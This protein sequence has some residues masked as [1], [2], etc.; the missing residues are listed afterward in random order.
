MVLK[1]KTLGIQV[2]LY[3][4][5]ARYR[6]DLLRVET[7]CFAHNGDTD[8][9]LEENVKEALFLAVIKDEDK[10]FGYCLMERRWPETAYMS[11]VAIEPDYQ[12][13]GHLARLVSG[14]EA[15]LIR[16]GFT[17]I[18]INARIENGYAAKIAKAYAGRIEFQYDHGSRIGPLTFFRIVLKEAA[19]AGDEPAA[20]A[21][22]ASGG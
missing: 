11:I 3:A 15:E 1:K 14:V 10:A 13:K 12:G 8:E 9:E 17:H 18:E 16:V 20:A 6:S 21:I 5:F 22:P 2:E 19:V 7:R 4:P